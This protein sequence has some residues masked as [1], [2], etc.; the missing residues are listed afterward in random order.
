MQPADSSSVPSTEDR[1]LVSIV[2]RL[3]GIYHPECIYLFG[4][5]ARGDAHPDSDYDIMIVV[6]DAM[7]LVMQDTGPAY[8][9][10]WRLG[11]A[12]DLLVWTRAQFDSRLHLRA[13]LPS[14]VQREGKLLYAA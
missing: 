10:L 3:V 6:P 5:A 8:R 13:S 4:S 9:A 14:T 12:V 2:A 11:A 7:P 1:I